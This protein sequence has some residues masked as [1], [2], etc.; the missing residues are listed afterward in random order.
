MLTNEHYKIYKGKHFNKKR[1]RLN[2]RVLV[3]DLDETLGS[4]TDLE[5]LWSAL[6]EYTN[7]NNPIEFNLLLDLYPEFL[8]Y[9]IKPILEY[10]LEKKK[11]GECSKIYIYTNNQCELGWVER[12]TKY[13][14]YYLK[15]RQTIFNQII[16][17]FKI[18]NRRVEL[19]RTTSAKTH[20]DF[21]K[22][23][24][25]PETTEI[26]FLDNS[27][28]SQMKQDRIY[29]IQ[30]KSYVHHLS[31]QEII[32]RFTSSILLLS[33]P[34]TNRDILKNYLLGYFIEH[35]A[36]N[37]GNP[38]IRDLEL[39]ILIAQKLMYHLRDFFYIANPNARTKKNKQRI[40]HFTRKTYGR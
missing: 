40:G 1:R 29:Y 32:Q 18:G 2:S 34:N 6:K 5:I 38:R 25:M 20:S 31:T 24:L 8:R 36:Y 30:P 12:I 13:F 19:G 11:I 15:T 27:S 4:F 33:I 16:H 35:D 3:F 37:P 7:N 23:T 9:G 28:Y 17:A 26:F 22:C 21:I 39:D 14:D 10:L